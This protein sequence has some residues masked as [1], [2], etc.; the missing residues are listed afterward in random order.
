MVNNADTF[1]AKTTVKAPDLEHRRKINFNIGKYNAAV[2]LGKEQFA[3]V[4]DVRQQAKNIK[5]N[6]LEHLDTYLEAFEK[7]IS[8]I[9]GDVGIGWR[10]KRANPQHGGFSN[11]VEGFQPLPSVCR[12]GPVQAA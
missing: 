10:R 7:N 6:A 5:W 4:M 9:L 8:G 2:P 11:R 3:N 12:R 1:I